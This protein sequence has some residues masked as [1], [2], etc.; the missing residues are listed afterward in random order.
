MSELY[1][2][3]WEQMAEAIE[4]CKSRKERAKEKGIMVFDSGRELTDYN[5]NLSYSEGLPADAATIIRENQLASQRK[6][7]DTAASNNSFNKRVFWIVVFVVAVAIVVAG[8]VPHA[9]KF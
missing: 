1:Q 2:N 3:T 5:C 4:E 9:I 8:N 7:Y 6:E